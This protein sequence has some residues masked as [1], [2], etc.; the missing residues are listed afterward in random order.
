MA[1]IP[2]E[3]LPVYTTL[4][5][6]WTATAPQ[7]PKPA[8]ATD[9]GPSIAGY[10]LSDE[11]TPLV[12]G[13]RVASLHRSR[14]ALHLFLWGIGAIAIV[15]FL[16]QNAGLVRCPLNDVP[17][18]EKAALRR[19]WRV[20]SAT[21][22]QSRAEFAEEAAAYERASAA[23][24]AELEDWR[25][26]REEEA[27]HRLEVQRRSEGV[28]WTEPRG[29]AR[30]R[31]Y[32]TRAYSAYLRDVPA[33]LNWLEVCYAMPPVVIHGRNVSQPDVCELN[34]R[35]EI[36]GTWYV[37]SG[38]P[39]CVSNWGRF[40]DKGCAPGKPGLRRYEAP[41]SGVSEGNDPNVMCATT[42]AILRRVQ[43]NG[44]ESC[45]QKRSWFWIT[46]T[47]G[48]WDVPDSRWC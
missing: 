25:A 40:S 32:G 28:W 8:S 9:A 10:P 29:E 23:H 2:W 21:W 42:P 45:E 14:R 18:A 5:P 33:G 13:K 16:S 4:P 11:G 46:Y 48:T 7:Q 24:R 35:G 41:M 22:A 37:S 34:G 3:P 39:G 1:Y 26:Q 36:V 15:L 17:A 20:E 43:Y 47:V 12:V 30:C 31:A 27:R 38:E 6:P 44:A 19:E